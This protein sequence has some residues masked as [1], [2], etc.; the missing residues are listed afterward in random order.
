[1]FAPHEGLSKNVYLNNNFGILTEEQFKTFEN[2]RILKNSYSQSLSLVFMVIQ[3]LS[4]LNHNV[5]CYHMSGGT[6]MF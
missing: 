6:Q 1:M 5:H 2:R 4:D 3:S